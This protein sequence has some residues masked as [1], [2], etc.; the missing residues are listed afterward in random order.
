MIF[1]EKMCNII[2]I[3]FLSS[4][5]LVLKGAE[6]QLNGVLKFFHI[7]ASERH[8]DIIIVKFLSTNFWLQ[9]CQLYFV[10]WKMSIKPR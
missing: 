1:N 4:L 3:Y 6:S 8:F 5:M 2:F 9:T 7:L 10:G